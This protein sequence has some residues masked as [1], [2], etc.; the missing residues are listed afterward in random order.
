MT[1][2]MNA[3]T[4]QGFRLLT[5]RNVILAVRDRFW[6]QYRNYTPKHLFRNEL[7]VAQIDARLAE[8][9]LKTCTHIEVEAAMGGLR[10]VDH[11]CDGCSK[12]FDIL[13]RMGDEPDYETRWQDLCRDC[14]ADALALIDTAINEG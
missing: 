3:I 7:S 11:A 12:N 9:D 1:D 4:S 10:W 13:V 2:I 6:E 5:R 14:L 8:L